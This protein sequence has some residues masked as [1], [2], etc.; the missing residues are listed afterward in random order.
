MPDTAHAPE[1]FGTAYDC[2]DALAAIDNPG[3]GLDE[4]TRR[5]M[6][7]ALMG[8]TASSRT[9]RSGGSSRSRRSRMTATGERASLI[10][11]PPQLPDKVR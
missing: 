5:P 1:D 3:I 6:L 10:G 11:P 9:R 8:S 7:R 4:R 2:F